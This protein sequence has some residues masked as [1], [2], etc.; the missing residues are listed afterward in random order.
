[1][2]GPSTV[3]YPDKRL[4][5][6]SKMDSDLFY[7]YIY[8]FYNGQHY[9]PEC[10]MSHPNKGSCPLA[11]SAKPHSFIKGHEVAYK[12]HPWPSQ[13]IGLHMSLHMPNSW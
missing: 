12:N 5:T 10:Q 9:K 13:C 7:N 6:T 1:M 11:V 2:L 3:I 8:K 4:A